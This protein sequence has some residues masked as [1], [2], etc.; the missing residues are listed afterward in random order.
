M[1]T[2]LGIAFLICLVVGIGYA[3]Y[4]KG[5]TDGAVKVTTAY[6]EESKNDWNSDPAVK[7]S[8]TYS[9]GYSRGLANGSIEARQKTLTECGDKLAE[10]VIETGN[11]KVGG[12]LLVDGY[13]APSQL[14]AAEARLRTKR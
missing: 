8:A 7:H 12:K 4:R 1:K 2:K 11:A 9:M 14:D 3:C 13:I 5:Y 6:I 10:V